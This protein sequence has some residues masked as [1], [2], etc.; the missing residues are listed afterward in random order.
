MAHL[1][2]LKRENF[3]EENKELRKLLED[4]KLKLQLKT[5]ESVKF[6][7]D[8]VRC[9]LVNICSNHP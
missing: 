6:E 8:F 3:V 2:K 9:D 7:S 1:N 5:Q 4:A